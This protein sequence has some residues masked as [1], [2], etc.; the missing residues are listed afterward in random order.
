MLAVHTHAAS[1]AACEDVSMLLVAGDLWA[2]E[3]TEEHHGGRADRG[4]RVMQ[5]ALGSDVG[6]RELQHRA[7]QA[8]VLRHHELD[9]GKPAHVAPADLNELVWVAIGKQLP[10][11]PKPFLVGVADRFDVRL[12]DDAPAVLAPEVELG[13]RELNVRRYRLE[14]LPGP[15]LY[16]FPTDVGPMPA[17]VQEARLGV[18]ERRGDLLVARPDVVRAQLAEL[19]DDGDRTLHGARLAGC[20]QFV[21]PAHLTRS[22]SGGRRTNPLRQSG[23]C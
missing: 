11:V 8:H 5:P 1:S 3:S 12:D 14:R 10:P 4:R 21:A 6:Q 19:V 22:R 7:R 23:G 16:A 2:D 9:T 13:G 18:A 15:A 17:A 20:H